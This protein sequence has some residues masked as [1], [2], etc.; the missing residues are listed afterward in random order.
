MAS[1]PWTGQTLRLL[2]LPLQPPSHAQAPELT[3]TPCARSPLQLWGG[4]RAPGAL[5]GAAGAFLLWL[6]FLIRVLFWICVRG[7]RLEER[8]WLSERSVARLAVPSS[9]GRTRSLRQDPAG[10]R[11]ARRSPR[12]LQQLSATPRFQPQKPGPE[13][14]QGGEEGALSTRARGGFAPMGLPCGTG[15]H[16]TPGHPPASHPLLRREVL[17]GQQ[18]HILPW[19]PRNASPGSLGHPVGTSPKRWDNP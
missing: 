1:E 18:S 16:P 2:L 17:R 9:P 19:K 8:A 5:W 7:S 6:L 11:P 12:G 4:L 10:L 14:E 15:A 3:P 13:D